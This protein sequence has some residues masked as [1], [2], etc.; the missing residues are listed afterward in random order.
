M[1][2]KGGAEAKR[3][4]RKCVGVVVVEFVLRFCCVLMR[5]FRGSALEQRCRREDLACLWE[6][7]GATPQD[8]SRVLPMNDGARGLV[9]LR[10]NLVFRLA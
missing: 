6:D 5:V 1:Q 2:E 10:K 3:E 8:G 4:E 9:K 7:C